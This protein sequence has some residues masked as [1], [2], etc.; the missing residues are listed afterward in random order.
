MRIQV[1]CRFLKK[2]DQIKIVGSTPK[3]GNWD[4]NKG[5]ELASVGG[6]TYSVDIDLKTEGFVEYKFIIKSG[7]NVYWQIGANNYYDNCS[8]VDSLF[9]NEL[10]FEN[11]KPK[12]SGVVAPVFSLRH[13]NDWGIGDFYSL[14]MLVDFAI[15]TNMS[16]VQILPIN[17]TCITMTVK[18]SYP[19]NAISTKAINPLF[20]DMSLFAERNDTAKEANLL[21]KV[22]YTRGSKNKYVSIWNNIKSYILR[23]CDID[24]VNCF[25]ENN[26]SWLDSYAK[27]IIENNTAKLFTRKLNRYQKED[28]LSFSSLFADEISRIKYIQYVL[29]CQLKDVNDYAIKHNVMIKGDLP[30]GVNPFGLDVCQNRELFNIDFSAGAPPDDFA[31]DGQNWG[32]PTYNWDIMETDN[33]HWWRERMSYMSKY[34]SAMRIDHILG[35]FR[36]WQIPKNQESGLLG[37]FYPSIPIDANYVNANL[38]DNWDVET[39]SKPI[40]HKDY[41]KEKLGVYFEKAVK[42]K[43]LLIH[44]NEGFFEIKEKSQK[45]YNNC[46]KDDK[47]LYHIL[48]QLCT[49]VLFIN[50]NGDY[51]PRIQ[52]HKTDIINRIGT[53]NRYL[54]EN[55]ANDYFFNRNI[56]LW[57]EV[58]RK[59]LD[60]IKSSSNIL[61]CAEDLGMIPSCVP[62]VLSDLNIMTLEIERMPKEGQEK[63]WSNLSNLPYNSVL[64]TSTHDM[65]PIKLYWMRLSDQEKEEYRMLK[66]GDID[67]KNH[68]EVFKKILHNHLIASP[69]LSIIPLGDWLSFFDIMNQDAK[70]EQI[71]HPE[72]PDNIWD[73][74]FPFYMENIIDDCSVVDSIS[75]LIRE[76]E[77]CS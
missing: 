39:L 5:I 24:D 38:K 35:F 21:K 30:I 9:H 42:N 31:T 70:D 44:S 51:Y 29:H 49:E 16:V 36:I 66:L 12:F 63:P 56:S 73:Y 1:F 8:D 13:K 53:Q 6:F 10:Q 68:K 26:N 19:Y 67:V 45:F 23:Y 40:I 22:D 7:E 60:A 58:A 72:N 64:A 43:F 41:A 54:V 52:P 62:N 75:C 18:D 17:D 55:V 46:N 74:R 15:K 77:R 20:M 3:L 71:N 33:F 48:K 69:I 32:F 76:T 28:G 57:D 11:Y 4:T 61:L 25:F 47:E 2:E 34:F 59:R 65:P 37:F 14:R 27:F 50:H